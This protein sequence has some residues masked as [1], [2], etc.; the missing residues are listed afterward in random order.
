MSDLRPGRFLTYLP[1][2]I[3]TS[4]PFLQ[5]FIGAEP[6][7]AGRLHR[8]RLHPVGEEPIPQFVELARGRAED[9]GR[10]TR[11]RKMQLFTAHINRRGCGIQY[12]QGRCRH[13]FGLV[14]LSGPRLR[15][16]PGSEKNKS[17]QREAIAHQS[18]RVSLAG[19]NLPNEPP[20]KRAHHSIMRSRCA[21]ARIEPHPT[22]MKAP[23]RAKKQ[24][25]G[26]L[27]EPETPNTEHRTPNAERC[28]GLGGTS[29][30]D[31]RRS[32]FSLR[33]SWSQCA[34]KKAWALPMN[35]SN[36][37]QVLDCASPL[38]LSHPARARKSGEGAARKRTSQSVVLFYRTPRRCRA[39]PEAGAP[40]RSGSWFQCMRKN[41]RRFSRVGRNPG[42]T[43]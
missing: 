4:R 18:M 20:A 5:H 33:G 8:H 26:S 2:T 24:R 14:L 34:Q 3:T 19:T 15:A 40:L 30:F 28:G 13:T 10:T 37:R 1:L 22:R 6:I 12:R 16:R 27:H 32:M 25:R 23:M 17:L 36:V 41:E 43:F 38:A 29:M 39:V 9:F 21:V 7:D 31:V 42:P 11:N 35:R